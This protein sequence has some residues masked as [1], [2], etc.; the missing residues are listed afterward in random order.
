MHLAVRGWFFRVF[1]WLAMESS[2]ISSEQARLEV[3]WLTTVV[4]GREMA[5]I[6]VHFQRDLPD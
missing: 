2:T 6:Y 4:K 3:E 5:A 1:G